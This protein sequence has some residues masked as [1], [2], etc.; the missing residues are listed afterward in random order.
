[1]ENEI[2]NT[3]EYMKELFGVEKNIEVLEEFGFED[4]DGCG[5]IDNLFKITREGNYWL[6]QKAQNPT[7]NNGYV[8]A[9]TYIDISDP[10]Q[11]VAEEERM[12]NNFSWDTEKMKEDIIEFAI[13]EK[14]EGTK[15]DIDELKNGEIEVID[16]GF[17][18]YIEVKLAGWNETWEDNL[19][20]Y[21]VIEEEK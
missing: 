11:D 15:V 14:D 19:E 21:M 4:F 1:M 9:D 3:M 13:G 18:E 16:N 5:N 8:T 2:K 20:S 12:E 6:I 17:P 7:Q 10:Y